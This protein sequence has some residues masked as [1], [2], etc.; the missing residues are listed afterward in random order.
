MECEEYLRRSR[1]FRRLRSGLHGQLVERYGARLLEDG[2]VGHGTWRCL[3]V[4]GPGA[5]QVTID[6]PRRGVGPVL[7]RAIV[8]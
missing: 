8:V 2:L 4:V 5:K 7:T 3:N 1:L 6:R